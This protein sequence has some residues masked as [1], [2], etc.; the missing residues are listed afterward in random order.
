MMLAF[1]RLDNGYADG[2]SVSIPCW[3]FAAIADDHH[4]IIVDAFYPQNI[5]V[6]PLSAIM[7]G[8]QAI[9]DDAEERMRRWRRRFGVLE[10][11]LAQHWRDGEE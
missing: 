10:T 3:T 6:I 11:L 9:V 7:N 2:C 1:H 8:D 5:E 4:A